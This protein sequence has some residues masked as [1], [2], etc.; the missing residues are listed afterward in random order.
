MGKLYLLLAG[1]VLVV[2]ITPLDAQGIYQFWGTTQE[3]AE[4][5][6]GTLFTLKPNGTAQHIKPA[7]T[8]PVSGR[9]PSSQ[10]PTAFDGKLY[11]LMRYGGMN[12]DGIIY[13][14]DPATGIFKKLI[15]LFYH[16]ISHPYSNFV[17]HNNKMYATSADGGQGYG[18][19]FQ[20]DP[21]NK[22]CSK[23]ADFNLQL[24][25]RPHG[26]LTWTNDKF[27][28]LATSA[29]VTGGG[30]IFSFDPVGNEL[31]KRYDFSQATGS[32]PFGS[33]Q[34]LN[35]L[36]WSTTASGGASN[37]G[38]IFSFDPD[39]D[40]YQ[41]KIDFTN[42]TGH[43]PDGGLVLYGTYFYGV[44]VSGG[45]FNEGTLYQYDPLLNSIAKRVD[46]SASNG[47]R[48]GGYLCVHNFRLY[49]ITQSGG[50]YNSGV[51]FEFNPF[52]QSYL[53][54]HEL[55]ASEGRYSWGGMMD[56]ED[57]LYGFTSGGA[58]FDDGAFYQYDPVTDELENQVEFGSYDLRHPGGNLLY[59]D[60]RVF[61]ITTGGG[62]AQDGGI[63]EY[64]LETQ[65]YT[66]R[67]LFNDAAGDISIVRNSG[68][69]LH[70]D[71]K[72][73]GT[74]PS[75]GANDGGTLFSF[76]PSINLFT[77]LYDFSNSTGIN[78][79]GQL[80]SYN[81][82]L[83]GVT[84]AGSNNNLG[85]LFEYLPT[86][87]ELS[88]RVV[89]DKNKGE[90]INGQMVVYNDR[91]YG[92]AAAGGTYGYGTIWEYN[93]VINGFATKYH[94]EG[95][96]DGQGMQ[97]GLELMDG[98][99]YG[100][101]YGGL[102]SS[103]MIF[104]MIPGATTI[105]PLHQFATQGV[106]SASSTLLA[107][108]HKLYGYALRGESPVSN[109]GIF[110]FD[111]VTKILVPRTDFFEINGADPSPGRILRAPAMVASGVPG[112]CETSGGAVID[113]ANF[114][115]W[116]PFTND[117]GDAIAEIK[118]NGNVLG[119]VNV[120]YYVHDADTR[121]DGNGNIYLDRNITITVDNQPSTPVS[122][123][124]YV[125]KT[126]F[127][128]LKATPNS[129]LFTHGQL[130]VFKNEDECSASL[131]KPATAV[132]TIPNAWG[133]DYVYEAD[134]TSF[135][136]FYF[137]KNTISV[138]PVHI[139]SFTGSNDGTTN[140]LE[141]AAS[142]TEAVTFYVERSANGSSF[143]TIGT[144]NANA[145]DCGAGF[146]LTDPDA[147]GSFYYRIR[148]VE[149]NTAPTYSSV[150]FIKR[151]DVLTLSA[152]V[153]P[154]PVAGETIGLLVT[155]PG[156]K[157]VNIAVLDMNG[158]TATKKS[159]D[160]V[161]GSNRISLPGGGLSNGFYFIRIDDGVKPLTIKFIKK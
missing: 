110:E 80:V 150:I 58:A 118:A 20:F 134:V 21:V 103:G 151:G 77:K 8:Y 79:D 35:N 126:E 116:V 13:E 83:Y 92:T 100:V 2:F 74:L 3:G 104:E 114:N 143:N 102:N 121:K 63:Y 158:R 160:I 47:S 68:L 153:S 62:P 53:V 120:K 60:H 42:N 130:Q 22:T 31:E 94:F 147:D 139:L 70:T 66:I 96:P 28:G 119:R 91:F 122:L 108:N 72:I 44:T 132:A 142:C 54:K 97:H 52:N 73:Y 9:A 157:R 127:T 75:G 6:A 128:K 155:S 27:Y 125:R 88:V 32:G 98:K 89:I 69:T 106:R 19:I 57:K 24:G 144:V 82:K 30:T 154:N 12:D 38:V 7:F 145:S 29:G 61:G 36:L 26:E 109:S 85:T 99:L 112:Q 55:T 87:N 76:D 4:S 64:D 48:P 56:Y 124:L 146:T 17:L 81:G 140:K 1:L 129:G 39:T 51:I 117:N 138:L 50:N 59:A 90:Y 46:M 131:D 14:Y 43:S 152:L 148:M 16:G 41:K 18:T 45:A 25:T 113:A 37:K 135:S 137:G 115:E 123:R 95:Q 149:G 159:M 101:A 105:T 133:A 86:T 156:N 34:L 23:K 49:G 40:E 78:P 15:D 141:W 111:P 161:K 93:P 11:G 67:Y 5:G 136:S 107:H 65:K 71:G 84:R 10:A 33:L